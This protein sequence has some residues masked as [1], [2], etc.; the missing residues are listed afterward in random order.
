MPAS[1]GQSQGAKLQETSP[2]RALGAGIEGGGGLNDA[3][4]ARVNQQIE[5]LVRAQ[6][7]RIAGEVASRVAGL[8]SEREGEVKD[9]IE[10]ELKSRIAAGVASSEARIKERIEATLQVGFFTVLFFRPSLPRTRTNFFTS[11]SHSLISRW[12]PPLSCGSRH[13]NHP[14]FERG[15]SPARDFPILPTYSCAAPFVFL[16]QLTALLPRR[17]K[18]SRSQTP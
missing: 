17:V 2:S 14:H 10:R 3:V 16:S 12:N 8:A 13:Q 9:A 7:A 11:L 18:R 1:W 15:T 6:S 5:E 4:E